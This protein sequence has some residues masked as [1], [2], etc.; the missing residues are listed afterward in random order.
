ML[1]KRQSYE[2]NNCTQ[3]QVQKILERS[4]HEK[5]ILNTRTAKLGK[6]IIKISYYDTDIDEKLQ[7]D[8]KILILSDPDMKCHINFQGSLTHD[9]ISELWNDLNNISQSDDIGVKLDGYQL[10]KD[11][12]I[13]K[14]IEGIEN[15]GFKIDTFDAIEFIENFQKKYNRLPYN[16]EIDP[17]TKSYVVSQS[18]ESN[19]EKKNS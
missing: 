2:L 4:L 19:T 15:K 13:F 9:Q 17:I 3:E 16:N 10:T 14:I 11:E 18:E 6:R 5:L 12:A 7:K 8:N 1:E